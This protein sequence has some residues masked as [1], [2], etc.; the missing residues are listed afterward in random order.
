MK[1]YVIK[2]RSE[3]IQEN[4][5]EGIRDIDPSPEFV[6][7]LEDCDIAVMQRGWT[8]SKAAVDEWNRALHVLG[9]TC[10]EGYN[11]TL[12]TPTSD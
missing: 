12:G 8:R 10:S 2:K 9:K 7:A 1:Y 3:K 5:I 6:D 4:L 11:Y